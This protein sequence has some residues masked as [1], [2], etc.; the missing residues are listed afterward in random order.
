MA[1]ADF[2]SEVAPFAAS[3]STLWRRALVLGSTP[4]FALLNATP[5]E[6]AANL[7]PLA[8]ALTPITA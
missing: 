8:L 7:H 4:E 1:Y 6:P 3:Q 2:Y 5:T